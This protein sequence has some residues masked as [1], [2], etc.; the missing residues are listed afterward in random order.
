MPGTG[1]STF[2]RSLGSPIYHKPPTKWWDGYIPI[3]GDIGHQVVVFDD[4]AGSLT[5]TDFKLLCDEAP[6][7]VEVKGATLE[8]NTNIIVFTTNKN[9]LKWYK[10]EHDPHAHLALKRR[11][12][13][14]MI[15]EKSLE[16]SYKNYKYGAGV[17]GWKQFDEH[18]SQILPV[19]NLFPLS[20]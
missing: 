16:G 7:R 19:S 5:W 9:P 4:Y 18:L 13:E 12:T 8:F 14:W 11:V 20:E 6:Y 10:W 1:K 15:F 2:A 17:D 3:C